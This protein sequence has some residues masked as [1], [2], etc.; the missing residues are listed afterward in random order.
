MKPVLFVGVLAFAGTAFAQQR[1]LQFDINN[2]SFQAY[3]AG[4]QAAPFGGLT[5]TG[6]LDFIETLSVT[7]LL[8]V[9]VR[10]GNDPYQIVPTFSGTLSDL[11]M[12]VNLSNG[13][14]TGGS[15]SFDVNGGPPG[16]G[17]RYTATFSAAGNVTTFVGGG[18]KVEGLSFTGRFSDSNFAGVP[19][20]DFFAAQ[21]GAFLNGDFIAFR[22]EPNATG[23]GQADTDIFVTNVPSAGSFACLGLGGLLCLPRRRR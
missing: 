19:I 7:Q 6:R 12:S 4:G 23:G 11:A 9:S 15:L 2:T 21:T 3:N 22:I 17:D 14:V 18:F 20:P 10:N 16:G 8:S 1:S 13:A 5:H